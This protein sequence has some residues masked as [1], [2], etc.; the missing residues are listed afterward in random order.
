[1]K[2]NDVFK[3]SFTPIY[4]KLYYYIITQRAAV[5]AASAAAEVM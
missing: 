1:M 2:K 5:L 4:P 3:C